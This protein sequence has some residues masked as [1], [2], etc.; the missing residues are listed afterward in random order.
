MWD[1][2]AIL[3][4]VTRMLLLATLLFALVMAGR[5]AAETWL[6]V[7]EVTVS[8]VLHP[9]TRQ[10]IRPVLA[11][12]SGGLFSVDL[13][14]AQRGFETLPWV[15]SASVRRVWPHG[16]AVALEERVPAAAWNNLAILDVHGEVFAARPWPDLPRL[17]GPDWMAKEAARRYGEFVLALAPGGWRIAAIQVD[18]RH[19]WTVALSGGPTIDL[20]RD[21]LAERLKRFVTFYPLAAS[22]MAAIRRVDMRYPNGFAVQGGVGQS[23][24][25]EEQRT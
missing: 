17:S 13:A 7:R 9:E 20:G 16:L 15:R 10:A 23:G 12:L 14:A 2:P 5:Q 8:G 4:R 18:A 22:R 6:P 24:P 11:G 3:N 25:A 19:T 21:R 1:N